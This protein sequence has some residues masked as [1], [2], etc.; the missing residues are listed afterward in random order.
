VMQLPGYYCYKQ[1]VERRR[2]SG[3]Y[4]IGA[5][6]FPGC[7]H[8]ASPGLVEPISKLVLHQQSVMHVKAGIQ[9]TQEKARFPFTQ[10]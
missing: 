9:K 2:L 6:S 5:W 10:I 3:Q 7:G 4:G 8:G 1:H